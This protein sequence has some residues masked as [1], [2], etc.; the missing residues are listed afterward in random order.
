MFPVCPPTPPLRLGSLHLPFL[1]SMSRY[2]VTNSLFSPH[3]ASR[4]TALGRAFASV[5]I[6]VFESAIMSAHAMLACLATQGRELQGYRGACVV[7]TDGRA[8]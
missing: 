4:I 1:Q 3:T 8:F 5:C 7:I 2:W 6:C